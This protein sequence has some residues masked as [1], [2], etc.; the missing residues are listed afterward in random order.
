MG[1][2]NMDSITNETLAEAATVLTP[3]SSSTQTLKVRVVLLLLFCGGGG[4]GG[5]GGRGGSAGVWCWW[6]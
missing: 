1:L 6:L 3:H 2:Y 4:G 5:D